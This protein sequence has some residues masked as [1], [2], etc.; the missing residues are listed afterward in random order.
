MYSKVETTDKMSEE[1]TQKPKKYK[2]RWGNRYGN[3]DTWD[4]KKSAAAIRDENEK[5]INPIRIKRKY[6]WRNKRE[7]KISEKEV[8][9]DEIEENEVDKDSSRENDKSEDEVNSENSDEG[10]HSKSEKVHESD[11]KPSV[12]EDLES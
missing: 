4:V 10:Y 9:N 12:K 8:Q 1:N 11:A 7:N 6:E 2:R 5:I 3:S